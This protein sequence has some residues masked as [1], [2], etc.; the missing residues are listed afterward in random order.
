MPFT[1][2]NPNFFANNP[3]DRASEKRA[4]LVLLVNGMPLVVIE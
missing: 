1:F 4:D 3:L 2:E